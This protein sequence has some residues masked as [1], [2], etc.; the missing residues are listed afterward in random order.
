M[1]VTELV[2]HLDISPLNEPAPRNIQYMVVT[3]VVFQF[4]ISSHPAAPH[5]AFAGSPQSESYAIP[6]HAFP[7]DL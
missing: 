3:E 1:F 4:A 7:V 5:L 6:Q 2:S